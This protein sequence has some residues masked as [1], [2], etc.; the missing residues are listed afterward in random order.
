MGA[1][2]L[3]WMWHLI[4]LLLDP[5]HCAAG[6]NRAALHCESQHS[7]HQMVQTCKLCSTMIGVEK[8]STILKKESTYQCF[9]TESI[10]TQLGQ[11][12]ETSCLHL[13]L[14]CPLNH[15]WLPVLS[16]R[17]IKRQ[18]H[19]NGPMLRWRQPP[20]IVNHRWQVEMVPH[21]HSHGLG[22]NWPLQLQLMDSA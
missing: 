2:I 13:K 8:K 16:Q 6:D 9:H 7:A 22:E 15:Q 5:A 20:N 10:K 18:D 14:A 11:G 19:Y 1:D 4:M 3:V 12:V 17:S 21:K